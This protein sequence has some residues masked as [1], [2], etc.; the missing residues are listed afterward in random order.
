[1]PG[2]PGIHPTSTEHDRESF[3]RTRFPDQQLNPT[4]PACGTLPPQHSKHT[5]GPGPTLPWET[6]RLAVGTETG[7]WY[8]SCQVIEQKIPKRFLLVVSVQEVDS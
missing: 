7:L 2:D 8:G 5:R 4:W 6:A 3:P 1:M